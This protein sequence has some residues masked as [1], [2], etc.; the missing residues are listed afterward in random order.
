VAA[1]ELKAKGLS[2][3]A[4]L[5][6]MG[7]TALAACVPRGRASKIEGGIV[8]G[9]HLRGHRVREAPRAR[10]AATEDV[11]IAILGAGI[12]GLSAA[13]AFERAGVRDFVLLELEDVPGGTARSGT[14]PITPYPWGA[15][16]VPV[17]S[18]DNRPLVA[19]L[20]E[21]GAVSGRDAAGKPVWA[22]QV[23]C[24]E[25]QERLF[26]GAQWH[27]GLYPRDGASP[28]DLR[29][30]GE[31]EA[32]MRRWS[33]WRDG[34]GRR[35]FA[36]P[37]ARGSDADEVKALDRRSM[38]QYMDEHNWSS[39]RLRWFVEYGC[40]DDFGATLGQTSAWAG[41]H[42]F[43]ARLEDDRREA[44]EFLTWPE[45]NGHLVAHLARS[46]GHRIRLGTL[47]TDVRTESDPLDIAYEDAAGRAAAL[48][49]RHV[50]F[51]L[52]RFLAPHLI[53]AYRDSAPP[54]LRE[55]MYG[56]WMVANLTL[57]ERPESR[58][59]PL[60]W[61]NVLYESP[62]LGYVVATHQSGRDQGPTVFTYYL[63]SLDE[64]PRRGRER[65]LGTSWA[66]WVELILADLSRAHPGIRA[67]VQRV[68]VYLWGHAMVR[69][70]PG[71]MWSEVL[72]ASS[73]PLGR[74]HF[75]HT[76]LSGMALFE[77]AQYWGIRAAEAVLRDRGQSFRSWL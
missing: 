47:V 62:S 76:D 46:A 44:A 6:A 14:G 17:P 60:A 48:R 43:A 77:E 64:D 13:W 3:R 4:A 32:E 55:T 51:A 73:R 57:R 11:G 61:D 8:G 9:N 67:L 15:H 33:Q 21:V 63:P 40:R 5:Q 37:R 19:V 36:I 52:P 68:D 59:F 26:H 27:E 49:A 16:Y 66:E 2:R 56:S 75:A 34:G 53:S 31:F 23:L 20:E 42:Y 1:L 18:A 30:L 22:E 29:Q 69:P 70:R 39:P 54:G 41:V 50:V 7:A 10:P 12:A 25:P 74:L 45:G 38:L 28:E 35:A 71:F 58:G 72:A 24:R 65:L